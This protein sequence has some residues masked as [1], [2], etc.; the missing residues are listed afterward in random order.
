MM[1]TTLRSS[2]FYVGLSYGKHYTAS[3]SSGSYRPSGHDFV[4]SFY[5]TLARWQ[6][7]TAFHSDP[8]DITGHPSFNALVDNALLFFSFIIDELRVQPSPLVWVLDDA[9]REK[10]Y[11]DDAIGDFAQMSDA[12]IAWSERNGRTF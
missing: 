1:A 3:N 8:S 10:P 6:R 4:T 5:A 9:F 7:E 2:N 12:W 11:A